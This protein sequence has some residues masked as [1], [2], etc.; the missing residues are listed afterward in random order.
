MLG[1]A[2][3]IVLMRQETGIPFQIKFMDVRMQ[4]IKQYE[5]YRISDKLF[6]FGSLTL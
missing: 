1:N 6:N 2:P 4:I 5:P 3:W